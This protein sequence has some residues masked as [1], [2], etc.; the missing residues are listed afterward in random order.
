[1]P[2][3]VW[4]TSLLHNFR[5]NRRREAPGTGRSPWGAE[6]MGEGVRR[7]DFLASNSQLL[8]EKS[9]GFLWTKQ[10][11]LLDNVANAETPN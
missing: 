6:L 1:M 2:A 9:M 4:L 10:A 5:R 7:M 11:A 8:L 3:R